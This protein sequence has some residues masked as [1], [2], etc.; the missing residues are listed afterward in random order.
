MR[1]DS[2]VAGAELSL[3]NVDD[4]LRFR[5]DD[6][7]GDGTYV[8]TNTQASSIPSNFGNEFFLTTENGIQYFF[9][10]KTGKLVGIADSFGNEISIFNDADNSRYI[11]K[12]ENENATEEIHV[13]YEQYGIDIDGNVC[14]RRLDGCNYSQSPSDWKFWTQSASLLFMSMATITRVVILSPAGG[15]LQ[16]LSV[17]TSREGE[18]TY[19]DYTNGDF[20]RYLTEVYDHTHDLT[21]TADY[22]DSSD[23]IT[24]FLVGD[25][26]L[27]DIDEVERRAEFTGRLQSNPELWR[28]T[29]RIW[30]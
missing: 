6:L 11:I 17:V 7:R 8:S 23:A 28:R 9:D 19:Y 21:L 22:F 3:V 4:D 29:D 18:S 13:V 25:E 15:D 2:D 27:M 20:S 12:N 24:D 5:F 14:C 26:T 10:N 30:L 16:N 1:P